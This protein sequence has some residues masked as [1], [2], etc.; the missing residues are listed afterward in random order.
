M[1]PLFTHG[2]KKRY[3]G[4][5]VW[6]EKKD[7]LLVR[8]Y[9]IRRSDSFDLQS[10]LL[11]R[12]FEKI[13][14]ENNEDAVALVRKTVQ[15]TMAGKVPAEDLVISRTCKGVNSYANPDSMTNVQAARKLMSL[16]YEFIPGMKVSWIVTD[17][18]AVP[19][20]VE[21]FVSGKEF[22]HVP[23]YR[24]Y[25]ERLAQT[26]SRITEVFGW[27]ERDLMLGSQQATLFNAEFGTG[28]A[29]RPKA[30]P[31]AAAAAPKKKPSSLDDFF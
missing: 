9:E 29:D 28:Q 10:D 26:A 20:Q 8:G 5:V 30:G 11:E 4:R 3:V 19:Q 23:D 25:A 24:Y 7:E 6:P 17:G 14:D 16:G 18:K 31:K 13:L 2:K 1:E 21:P 15:D 12:L 27:S 22:E